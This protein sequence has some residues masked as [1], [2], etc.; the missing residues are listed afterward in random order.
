M[1]KNKRFIL[2]FIILSAIIL[3][4]EYIVYSSLHDAGIVRSK[5]LEIILMILGFV[6][7]LIFIFSIRY[8][9]RRYSLFNSLLN[10]ISSV[11]ILI[12][13][14]IFI[15]YIFLVILISIDG[16]YELRL[17]IEIIYNTF[18][19]GILMIALYGIL[20]SRN[21]KIVRMEIDSKKLSK[22]WSNKKIIIIS[23]T[24]IGNINR[25]RFMKKIVK[26]MKSENPDIVF[27]VGDLIDG[28][29][30][31]YKKCFEPLSTLNPELGNYYVEGNH[32][33]YSKDYDKF[34][35]E[36]PKNLNDL[37]D[38]NIIINNTQIIGLGFRLKENADEII[39][40]LKLLDYNPNIPSIVLVHDPMNVPALS[41]LGVSLVLSGH[42]HS[43]QFFPFTLVIKYIYKKYAYGLNYTNNTASVTSCGVGT[44]V[45]PVRIG[46]TPEIIV[47]TIK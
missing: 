25:L 22:D 8:S 30:F 14:Y 29:A 20:N 9:F 27:N 17:P 13:S 2:I 15:I 42:T 7:P 23:D 6:F 1:N 33:K 45:A 31:P 43:G 34:K 40:R 24:H 36:F 37:T 47:L 39:S 35:L 28:A 4:S 11:W 18:F 21:I 46:S 3:I 10:V 38:K 19:V 32:E 26:I 12:V 16:Y 41:S 44:S 5:Q